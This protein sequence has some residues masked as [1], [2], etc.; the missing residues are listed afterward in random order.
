MITNNQI[1]AKGIAQQSGLDIFSSITN[2]TGE[3]VNWGFPDEVFNTNTA[4]ATTGA[5]P[6]TE[7]LVENPPSTVN[8]WYSYYT[9]GGSWTPVTP[10]AV[11]S[12]LFYLYGQKKGG[13][14]SYSGMYQKLSLIT[15]KE[16]QISIEKYGTAIVGTVIVQVYTPSSGDY[17]LVYDSSYSTPVTLSSESTFT[18]TFT[19]VS[20]NDILMIS[21]TTEYVDSMASININR[22]SIQEKQEYL[23]PVYAEDR[24]GNEHKIL[25]RD[26]GNILTSD[27]T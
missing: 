27:G 4:R 5:N 16:Y 7:S 11:S 14:L 13:N 23:V 6:Y 24:W 3:Y 22:I 8:V 25:R 2:Y 21:F 15:G 20:S 10:P 18:D 26:S 9:N 12:S 19:A 17:L 1:T